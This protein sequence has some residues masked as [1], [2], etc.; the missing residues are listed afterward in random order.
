ML[1]RMRDPSIIAFW[2]GVG[3]FLLGFFGTLLLIEFQFSAGFVFPIGVGIG[4]TILVVGL[5]VKGRVL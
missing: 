1:L 4:L 2:S 3:G 5:V